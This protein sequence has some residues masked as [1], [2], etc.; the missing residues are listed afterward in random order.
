MKEMVLEKS[1]WKMKLYG[2]KDVEQMGIMWVP[3]TWE[4]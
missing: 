1:N 4:Q 2:H 3:N